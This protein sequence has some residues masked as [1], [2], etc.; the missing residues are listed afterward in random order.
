[1]SKEFMKKT[2]VVFFKESKRQCTIKENNTTG[3][4]RR[5]VKYKGYDKPRDF[6]IQKICTFIWVMQK[7]N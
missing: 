6:L 2:L 5:P 4:V 1:M 3:F 7:C